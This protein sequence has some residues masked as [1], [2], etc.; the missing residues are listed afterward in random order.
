MGG[1][2]HHLT[3]EPTKAKKLILALGDF[4]RYPKVIGK[5]SDYGIDDYTGITHYRIFTDEN[6][7]VF[8]PTPSFPTIYRVKDLYDQK[9]LREVRAGKWLITWYEITWLH[10]I[11]RSLLFRFRNACEKHRCT[12]FWN[13]I[14]R[15]NNIFG[16]TMDELSD[17]GWREADRA[18]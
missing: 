17:T 4:H 8:G 5:L 14:A 9:V 3:L 12:Q 10:K 7:I 18:W 16:M 6:D 13:D 2:D 11:S 15:I 1:F